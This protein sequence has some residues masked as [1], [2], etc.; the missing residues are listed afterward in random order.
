[1]LFKAAIIN[2]QEDNFTWR[3]IGTLSLGSLYSELMLGT[4]QRAKPTEGHLI[5]QDGQLTKADLYL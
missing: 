4:L 2:Q 5:A 1:M 3:S